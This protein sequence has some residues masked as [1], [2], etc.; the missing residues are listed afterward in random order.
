M[1]PNRNTSDWDVIAFAD[2]PTLER[3]RGDPQVRQKDID[4]LV[5]ADEDYFEQPW[6]EVDTRFRNATI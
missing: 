6:I 1:R 5:A 3:M 2:A 4:L